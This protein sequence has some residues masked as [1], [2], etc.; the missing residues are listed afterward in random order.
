MLPIGT[1]VLKPGKERKV[2]NNYPW[3][4]RGEVLRTSGDIKD[5]T[6]ARLESSEGEFLAIGTWN[7][8]CRFRFRVLT[9]C[10]EQINE[11]FFA[12]RFATAIKQRESLVKETDAK[13][14]VYSEADQLPGLI[15]DDYAGHLVVQVRSLGM[16]ALKPIWLPALV[17]ASGAKS[18]YERSDM[19]GREEEGLP[20]TTGDLHGATPDEVVIE[21]SGLKFIVPLKSGLKTGF[22]LDQRNTRRLLAAHV[23]AGQHVLDAFCYTGAFSCHVAQVGARVKAIDIHAEA[24]GIARRNAKENGLDIDYEEANVF[25]WLEQEPT[26]KYDWVIL[27]PPAIAKTSAKRDALKWA[28][29]K[30]VHRAIPHLASGGRMIVCSCSY[31]LDQRELTEVCRLAASDR[32]VRIFLEGMT[33]QD[34]DHP[35]PLQFPESLYLK[36]AWL[37]VEA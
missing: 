20:P 23:T 12:S 15:V 29:W 26:Q 35:A 21:E 18:I 13:R 24:L 27:D 1:I 3:I 34:I 8:K 33:Y 32:G 10:D 28:V 31:Q 9:K 36:C 30:L 16:E 4:Q 22:Y 6:L 19:A 14:I 25:E 17:G 7:G 11:Q 2:R 5:G 37:R